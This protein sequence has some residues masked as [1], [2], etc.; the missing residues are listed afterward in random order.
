MNIFWT[1][2]FILSIS[3][4]TSEIPQAIACLCSGTVLFFHVKK[5]VIF[6][7]NIPLICC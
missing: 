7:S 6:N 4:K 1:S 5:R 2:H 3:P